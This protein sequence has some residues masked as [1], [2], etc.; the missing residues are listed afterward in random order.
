MALAGGSQKRRV[1]GSALLGILA[2]ATILSGKHVFESSLAGYAGI[3]LA[4]HLHALEYMAVAA[5]C[6][7]C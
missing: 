5:V 7:E 1:R 3:A 6:H 2:V 4:R